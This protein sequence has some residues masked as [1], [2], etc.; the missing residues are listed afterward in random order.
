MPMNLYKIPQTTFYP[1]YLFSNLMRGAS[2]SVHVTSPSY[3]GP[4]VPAFIHNLSVAT[5]D[6]AKLTKYIDVSAV[7]TDDRSEVRLAIVNRH[8]ADSFDIPILFGP[9]CKLAENGISVYEIYSDSL[10]DS[11]GFDRETV[12]TVRK[13]VTFNGIYAVKKH[14]FQGN[15]YSLR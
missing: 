15:R 14:S 9:S 3:Q 5:P 6:L 4:T 11:N 1:L 2:L 8:E 12:K 13:D 7:L 10:K